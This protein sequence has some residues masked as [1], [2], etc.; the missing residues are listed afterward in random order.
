[1]S[2]VDTGLFIFTDAPALFVALRIRIS[3]ETVLPVVAFRMDSPLN[4][5]YALES[6]FPHGGGDDKPVGHV[7]SKF[8]LL[9][10]ID[11]LLVTGVLYTALSAEIATLTIVTPALVGVK[12]LSAHEKVAGTRFPVLG[13]RADPPVRSE[14]IK[15]CPNTIEDALGT[16]IFKSA[17][18]TVT[19]KVPVS[20]KLSYS[21]VFGGV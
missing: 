9:T 6:A 19:V 3:A 15:L 5:V 12:E 13:L 21:V 18:V 20:E 14:L 4:R 2:G 16:T 1:M 11:M 8:A 7:T 10:V 17:L